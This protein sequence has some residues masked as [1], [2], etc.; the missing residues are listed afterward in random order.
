M[1]C[2]SRP[3]A[4][5]FA[6]GPKARR[7]TGPNRR[8]T[9]AA[10]GIRSAE[11]DGVSSSDAISRLHPGHQRLIEEG[12]RLVGQAASPAA[13]YARHRRIESLLFF[14]VK[15]RIEAALSADAASFLVVRCP[16]S[17]TCSTV[18]DVGDMVERIVLDETTEAISA[19][20]V[21][22][23]SAGP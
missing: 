1:G 20:Q 21:R 11:A 10:S 17:P 15:Q 14:A 3:D 9:W 16:I 22:R 6:S 13:R 5:T 19:T 8:S 4:S 12:L 23:L 18:R 7:N 2:S